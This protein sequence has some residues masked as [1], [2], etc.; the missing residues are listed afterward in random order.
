M[1]RGVKTL[2]LIL[3]GLLFC[4]PL[5][6][7]GFFSDSGVTEVVSVSKLPAEFNDTFR[8]IKKDG[9]FPYSRDGVVFSNREHRLPQQ[10]RGYYHE[11]TVKTP[12]VRNRGARRII[13]GAV[14]DCYY[15]DD[16]YQTFKRIK[17]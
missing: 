1:S 7:A 11:Y 10:P 4:S 2:W 13:C 8:L 5:A 15:T 3:I 16:H 17:E 6:Q 14:P 9:P 12:G